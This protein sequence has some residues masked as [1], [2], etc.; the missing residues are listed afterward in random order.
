MSGKELLG[1]SA[2]ELAKLTDAQLRI[3]F[4]PYLVAIKPEKKVEEKIGSSSSGSSSGVRKHQ[5]R[6]PS[7]LD[8]TKALF[9]KMAEKMGMTKLEE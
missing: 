6:G 1:Y 7:E 8:K 4:A 5:Y 2:K 3:I 9:N